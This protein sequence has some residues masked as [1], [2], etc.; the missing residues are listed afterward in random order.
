M[1]ALYRSAQ[2]FV[3]A[4]RLSGAAL[5]GAFAVLILL[6]AARVAWLWGG[7]WFGTILVA[8]LALWG[9]S[10]AYNAAEILLSTKP[11]TPPPPRRPMS[12]ETRKDDNNRRDKDR[13]TPRNRR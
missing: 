7:G 1:F 13:R 12:I 3:T 6:I 10:V 2:S 9:L 8:L 5:A 4:W 11:N